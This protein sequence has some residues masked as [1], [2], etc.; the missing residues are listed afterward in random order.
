MAWRRRKHGIEIKAA[1]QRMAAR[2]YRNNGVKRNDISAAA[3]Y[4]IWRRG[5]NVAAA[6]IESNIENRN[7]LVA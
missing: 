6:V 1:K 4:R 7:Q 2:Q 5:I 3:A